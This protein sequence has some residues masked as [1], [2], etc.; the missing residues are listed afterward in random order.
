MARGGDCTVGEFGSHPCGG[1]M[2]VLRRCGGVWRRPA[3]SQIIVLKIIP[4]PS[5]AC[6]L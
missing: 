1:M 5:F 2:Y 6:N 3:G 4:I